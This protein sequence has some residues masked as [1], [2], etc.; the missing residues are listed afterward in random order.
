MI[1]PQNPWREGNGASHR[2]YLDTSSPKGSC[3]ATLQAQ[4]LRRFVLANCDF[5]VY[6]RKH[7]CLLET[8]WCFRV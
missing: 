5:D 4:S 2:L 1:L 7:C 6:G 8:M 3:R